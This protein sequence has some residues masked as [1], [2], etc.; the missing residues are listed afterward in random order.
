ML[1][2]GKFYK[3]G[4]ISKDVKGAYCLTIK[5]KHYRVIR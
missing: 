1:V 4:K 3:N 2:H 5:D